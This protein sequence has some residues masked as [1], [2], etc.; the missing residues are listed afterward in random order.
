MFVVTLEWYLHVV[1]DGV[2]DFS[3]P[4]TNY[5]KCFS[6]KRRISAYNIVPWCIG[7]NNQRHVPV[8]GAY[9]VDVRKYLGGCAAYWPGPKTIRSI[10]LQLKLTQNEVV[11]KYGL[12]RK[13][14]TKS[15]W[16]EM[17]GVKCH[18]T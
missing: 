7:L 3:I 17:H 8:I 12:E 9:K 11:A 18:V 16:S 6:A 1:Y 4:T 5:N 13:I 2:L 14:S 15:T 10:I